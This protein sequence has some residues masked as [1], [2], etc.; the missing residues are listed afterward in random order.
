MK[1]IF[2][3]FAVLAMSMAMF[4]SCSDDDNDNV[5]ILSFEGDQ[6][7]ALIDNPQYNGPLLYSGDSYSWTDDATKLSSSF[8]DAYGD[9]KFW[10]G[11]AVI[12]NYI[13]ADIEN[14]NTFNY[15]LA[16]PVPN[17]SDNFVIVNYPA[18]ISFS[19]GV[20]RTIQSFDVSPTTYGLG[21]IT[22]GNE[23]A[24]PLTE[25]GFLTVIVTGYK[26]DVEVG[27]VSFDLARDGELLKSWKKVDLSSL[28]N[29]TSISFSFEGSDEA[30]GYI[31]S[32]LYFAFDNVAVKF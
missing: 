17:G 14:H 10:G 3:S 25:E 4:T 9:G 22:Y 7:T 2:L 12:S 26:K 29:V 11:G 16:V 23:Y 6:W 21:V 5:R 19:D 27:T 8:S 18:S 31:N 15:Q 30:G 13:D 24:T 32:P 1:K 20:A 28:G